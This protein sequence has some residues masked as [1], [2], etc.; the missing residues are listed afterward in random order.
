MVYVRVKMS[1]ARNKVKEAWEVYRNKV[2][3]WDRACVQQ[4]GG[5]YIGHWYTEYGDTGEIVFLVRY[6]DLAARDEMSK[7]FW[8]GGD[9]AVKKGLDEWLAYVPQANVKVMK[10]LPGSPLE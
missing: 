6:P 8:E 7:L 2:M 5:E 4:V 3:K 1:V 10:S 9:V